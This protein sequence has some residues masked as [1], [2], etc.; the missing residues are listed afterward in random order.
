MGPA[1]QRS[2]PCPPFLFLLVGQLVAQTSQPAT[3]VC[4]EMWVWSIAHPPRG[5]VY[6]Q[7]HNAELLSARKTMKF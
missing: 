6:P 7:W 4:C 1:P 2:I 3:E 5:Q